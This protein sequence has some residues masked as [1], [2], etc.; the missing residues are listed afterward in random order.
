MG[1]L[2]V[3]E[4]VPPLSVN[5]LAMNRPLR[6]LHVK[7]P[8]RFTWLFVSLVVCRHAQNTF[9]TIFLKS[10]GPKDIRTD[11]PNCQIHKYKFT[12]T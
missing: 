5:F 1:T 10:P 9:N 4:S 12:N 6:N 2:F 11:I 7:G 8:S 3:T